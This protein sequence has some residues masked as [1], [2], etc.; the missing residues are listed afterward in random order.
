M[1]IPRVRFTVRRLML[2][3]AIVALFGAWLAE[4]PKRRE[5]FLN[6]AQA[7]SDWDRFW[8]VSD[9]RSAEIVSVEKRRWRSAMERKYFWAADH[10]WLPVWPDAPEPE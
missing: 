10:P 3:V 1:P 4:A 5:R 8:F 2:A 7:S 6:I 9:G